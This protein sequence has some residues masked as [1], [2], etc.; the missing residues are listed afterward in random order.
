[1]SLFSGLA[2]LAGGLFGAQQQAEGARESA[3]AQIQAGRDSQRLY[4]NET[5]LGQAR[6]LLFAM[7]DQ[8]LPYLQA[9]LPRDRYQRLFGRP[10]ATAE[11][12]TRFQTELDQANQTLARYRTSG[13]NGYLDNAARSAGVDIPALTARVAELQQIISNPNDAGSPGQFDQNAI[14]GMTQGGGYL[15][16]LGSLAGTA[17]A[18]GD[19]LMRDYNA[20]TGRLQSGYQSDTGRLTQMG[21]AMGLGLA[22]YGDGER[23]RVRREAKDTNTAMDRQAVARLN[24]S[25]LGQSTLTANALSE[26]ARN[27]N[28]DLS[29]RLGQINDRQFQAGLG[30]Q[31]ANLGLAN[32]RATGATSLATDRATRGTGLQGQLNDQR[33]QYDLAPVAARQSLLTSNVFQPFLGQNTTQYFPGVSPSAGSANAWGGFMQGTGGTLFGNY[34]GGG[35]SQGNQGGQGNQN[36][37]QQLGSIFNAGPLQQG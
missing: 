10:A 30:I 16:Q 17:G 11:D 20:D 24:A 37:V 12:R 13:G 15:G 1:M 5:D 3:Q 31:Q 33:Y 4:T 27:V 36:R 23:Q 21:N 6:A 35:Q 28:N 18:R 34:L 9:T 22:S 8:A 2:G 25:G 7:G 32:Q 26:N 14:S 19:Q 29:D